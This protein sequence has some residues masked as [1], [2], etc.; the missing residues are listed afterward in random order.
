[1]S[2]LANRLY[3]CSECNTLSEHTTNHTGQIYPTCHGWC[4]AISN[5]HTAR[6]VVNLKQTPHNYIIDV[7]D[8]PARLEY[9]RGEIEAERISYS[10]I[11]DLE[12]LA[13]YIDAGDVTLL[14]WANV[15]ESEQ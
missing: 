14:Q 1:M 7:A 11:A 9:L 3:I 13:K 10:E 6:E 12:T 5:P 15:P 8:I 4:R 2:K